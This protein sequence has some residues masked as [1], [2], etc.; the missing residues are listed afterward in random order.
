MAA[1]SFPTELKSLPSP[2]DTDRDGMPD[3]WEIAN[4]LDP[5]RRDDRYFDLHPHY[6]N[7]EVY[8]NSLVEH[9]GK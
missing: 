7:L 8:I 9:I 5:N 4:G 6:T 2:K 3:E 1:L